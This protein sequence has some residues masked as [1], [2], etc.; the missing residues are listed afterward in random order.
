ML[1]ASWGYSLCIDVL[2]KLHISQLV[3]QNIATTLITIYIAT[4]SYI[5]GYQQIARQNDIERS[6]YVSNFAHGIT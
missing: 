5:E 3:N 2:I 4:T 6:P 1:R